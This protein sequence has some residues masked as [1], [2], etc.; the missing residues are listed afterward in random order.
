MADGPPRG[1]G[2]A[3]L[4]SQLGASASAE[5]GQRLADLGITPAQA[6]L[7]RV[8]VTDPGRSQRAIAQQLNIVPSSLV[9]LVDDLEQRGLVER[10]TDP[11][12]R[13]RHALHLT[14]AGERLFGRL[15]TVARAH[16]QD[17]TA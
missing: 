11:G 17:W 5:F 13:R 2:V 4:L 1:G 9:A 15:A 10:R 6:G 3:F 8:I 16:E 14:E 12:D 7:L